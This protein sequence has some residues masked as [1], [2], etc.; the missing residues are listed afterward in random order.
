M[1]GVLA[2]KINYAELYT[3]R[4]DGRYQGYY[5]IDG[6]R[7]CACDRDPEA[8]YWKLKELEKPKEKTFG[9]VL[10]E[11]QKEHVEKLERGTQKTY[12]AHIEAADVRHGDFALQDVTAAEINRIM[13]SEK[14][15]GYSYKHAAAAKSI[16]KQVFDF[17]I[18]KGYASTNP[19][20]SV[21]VPRG[22]PRGRREAP[23]NDV[24]T[25]VKNNIDKPYGLFPFLLLY[26]GFRTEEA[27]ALQWGDIDIKHKKIYCRR[28]V[29]LHGTPIIKSTKSEAG[30]R[31]VILLD[32][33][34]PHVK[35]PAK[36][37]DSDYIFSDNGKLLTR[38]QISS[39]W[40]NWCKAVGLAEQKTYSNRLRGNK[41]CTRT[42]WRPLVTPHQLRHGYATILY[43]AGIDEL[44]AMELMGHADIETTRRI[45]TH[46]RQSKRDGVADILNKQ[47]AAL[48]GNSDGNSDGKDPEHTEN[49]NF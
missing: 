13:L 41:K 23:E 11:W 6:K 42:E 34:L 46:L 44:T 8:L 29:D 38:S 35:K 36:A 10:D 45:Y 40:L 49:S 30:E 16:Y 26:T 28:A 19:A 5:Y 2:K 9:E 12:K 48:D 17:A 32:G 22:L 24:L 43:E 14:A 4:K 7:K 27:A 25:I 15:Q 39:R 31:E 37:K 47:F 18:V 21:Q 33:L 1:V 3:L 20:Q